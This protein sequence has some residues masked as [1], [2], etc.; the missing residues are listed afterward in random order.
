MEFTSLSD[1]LKASPFDNAYDAY[2]SRLTP[3]EY[4]AHLHY[5]SARMTRSLR[6]LHDRMFNRSDPTRVLFLKGHAG[7]GKTTFLHT[8][9]RDYGDYRHVYFDFQEMQTFHESTTQDEPASG[10]A[11]LESTA[12]GI[13][14]LMNRYLRSLHGVSETVHLLDSSRDAFKDADL[15]SFHLHEYLSSHTGDASDSTYLRSRMERFDL[16][17]TFACLFLHLFRTASAKTPKTILYF[18]NLDVASVESFADRFLVYFQHAMAMGYQLSRHELFQEVHVAFRRDYR[19]V[20]CLRD[21]NEA[22]LNS[23]LSDRLG[24][25]RK[26]F[27]ISFDPD[28]YAEITRK[29]IEYLKTFLPDEDLAPNGGSISAIFEGILHDRYF[30]DVFLPLYNYNYRDLSGMLAEVI[31]QCAVTETDRKDVV[32]LRGILMFGMLRKLLE[33]DFLGAIQK[34]PADTR[35]GDGYC[36][37]D[38]VMLTVLMNETHY[39]RKNDDCEPYS[40]SFLVDDL[41]VLYRDVNVI[42]RSIARTFFSHQKNRIHLVTLLDTKINKEDVFVQ[43]YSQHFNRYD[44]TD[45]TIGAIR[46]RNDLTSVLVRPNPSGF[47]CVRYVLP[48]FEFYANLVDN[49]SSLFRDPF[50]SSEGGKITFNFEQKIDRVYE[51][52]RRHVVSMKKFFENRYTAMRG[53]TAETFPRSKY[54]FR[55]QGVSRFPRDSGVSHTIRIVTTQIKYIDNFR[56]IHVQDREM[57][58]DMIRRLNKSLVSRIRQY[59]QLLQ[60]A[61]D[62]EVAL[63]FADQYMRHIREIERRNYADRET[64]IE[65]DNSRGSQNDGSDM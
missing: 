1:F 35:D 11:D 13:R 56:L 19:F 20:F 33:Q 48:H 6:E 62:R 34:T 30:R 40:L 36:Y 32:Q 59:V 9:M 24:F 23:H 58:D 60:Q 5:Q 4:Y 41:R 61:A 16:K 18:D 26:S 52:V 27:R 49:E 2:P 55:Q 15:I 54:C 37:I 39:D 63:S 28:T 3:E 12:E 22:V 25:A 46:T 64:R 65:L 21:S 31:R 45:D 7:N 51:Q 50:K 53:M 42:L 17:D 8:F 47:T 14:L 57:D 44:S 38:R 43:S 29:R 10:V